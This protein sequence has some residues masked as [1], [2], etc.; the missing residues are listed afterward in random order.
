MRAAEDPLDPLLLRHVEIPSLGRIRIVPQDRHDGV[1]LVQNNHPSMQIR[2]RYIISL[3]R[4]RC[5]HPKT[6]DDLLDEL[7][8]ETVMDQPPLRLMVPIANQ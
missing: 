4:H 2:Y 8:L 5:G 7:S 3:D 1:V 6:R